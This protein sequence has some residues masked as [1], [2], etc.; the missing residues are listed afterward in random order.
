MKTKFFCR[1]LFVAGLLCGSPAVGQDQSV[2]VDSAFAAVEADSLTLASAY[3]KQ[4]IALDP[5]SPT[6]VLLLVNLGSIQHQ[7]GLCKEAVESYSLALNYRPLAIPVLLARAATYLELGNEQKAYTDYC[8]VIDQDPDN[9]EALL[10]RAYIAVQQRAYDIARADYSH[11]LAVNPRHENGRLGLALLNQKQNRLQEATEQIGMLVKEYPDNVSY[12]LARADVLAGR[13]LCELALLD[14]ES[15]LKLDPAD[16]YI[17]VARAEV[18]LQMKRRRNARH[19]L[20]T[21][22]AMG[23][24]KGTLADLYRQ[25][26]R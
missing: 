1:I 18:Y 9:E 3:L 12:Y 25:C 5:G 10:F 17:Y 21:A 2:L 14:Y 20:D 8:N 13:D 4:A 19:D 7:L 15:A 24:A 11:L 16:P 22:V 23:V 6:N 26:G